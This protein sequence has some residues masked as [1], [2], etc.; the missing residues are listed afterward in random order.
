[1]F[2]TT[3]FIPFFMVYN[4]YMRINNEGNVDPEIL[5]RLEAAVLHLDKFWELKLREEKNIIYYPPNVVLFSRDVM[6]PCGQGLTQHG[7]F[8]CA[9]NI[10]LDVAWFQRLVDEYGADEGDF[11]ELYILAHEFGHH[12]QSQI[13]IFSRVLGASGADGSRVRGE[14]QADALAGYWT[15]YA[16]EDRDFPWEIT[17]NDINNALS[18]AHAV[19]DDTIHM[20]KEGVVSPEKFG[21]GTSRQRQAAFMFGFNSPSIYELRKF[22]QWELDDFLGESDHEEDEAIETA[23]VDPFGL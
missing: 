4:E 22:W 2:L 7:P 23:P 9:R 3:A 18:A 16:A 20:R 1:M 6:T 8:F 13:G 17:E 11:S 15:R 19:G 21:H 10:Y 12:I 14:L 5:E